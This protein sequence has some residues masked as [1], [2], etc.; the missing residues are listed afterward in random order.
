MSNFLDNKRNYLAS[1][2]AV[3]KQAYSWYFKLYRPKLK[4][5]LFEKNFSQCN[6]IVLSCYYC[7]IFI[8]ATGK[9]LVLNLDY[10]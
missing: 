8:L 10:Y 6:P 7:A 3:L 9:N 2:L 4:Y 1:T 5:Y